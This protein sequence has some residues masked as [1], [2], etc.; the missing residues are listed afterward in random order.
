MTTT[1][2]SPDI[3]KRRLDEAAPL[4]HAGL[5]GAEIAR[6]IGL[7]SRAAFFGMIERAR[8]KGDTRFPL[9]DESHRAR[10]PSAATLAQYAQ[11]SPLLDAG[12]S[13]RAVAARLGLPHS[14]VAHRI[15]S[16]RRCGLAVPRTRHPRTVQGPGQG[17]VVAPADRDARP[18]FAS[19]EAAVKANAIQKCPP[20]MA[21]GASFL[22]AHPGGGKA[23]TST[24]TMD[25]LTGWNLEQGRRRA[26]DRA[27]Q[28][29][30]KGAALAD[31][32]LALGH[33]P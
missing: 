24:L 14:T 31:A 23:I 13:T 22:G 8:R 16:F 20:G 19:I 32:A 6:R 21:P 17:A 33:A 27:V 10:G 3:V 11:I 5:S 12:L 7:N 30:R 15:V 25:Q 1:H 18:R 2:P 9:R 28:Q 29:R 4:W 26:A